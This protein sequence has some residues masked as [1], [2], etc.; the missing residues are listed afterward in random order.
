MLTK[1]VSVN[2]DDHQVR[3]FPR[4]LILA[5]FDQDGIIDPHVEQSIRFYRN[6]FDKIIMVSTSADTFTAGREGL[7][8]EFIRR[9]NVGYDFGSWKRGLQALVDP[10][11]YYEIVFANDSVYGPL[12]DLEPI[13]LAPHL[14]DADFWGLV[15]SDQLRPHV[16]SWFFCIRHRLI[17]S[18]DMPK[19]L[20]AVDTIDDKQAIIDNYELEMQRFFQ[21]RGWRTASYCQGARGWRQLRQELASGIPWD[22]PGK[23]LHYLRAVYSGQPLNPMHFCWK[24]CVDN[25]VPFVKV[26]LLRSNP[27]DVPL[28]RVWSYIKNKTRYPVSLIEQHCQ[29][30][31]SR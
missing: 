18:G 9:P 14:K 20:E 24:R 17:Q 12:N 11:A 30:T 5:H 29:R 19:F 1:I 27:L 21:E 23:A 28:D 22:K 4:A 26:E 25:G 2:G 8:D 31:G 13:F 16:Q 6:L 15:S 10:S 7:V 3:R